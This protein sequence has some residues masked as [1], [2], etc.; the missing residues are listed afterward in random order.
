MRARTANGLL[1]VVAVVATVGV[2]EIA[3]RAL[4]RDLSGQIAA[5][6]ERPIFF[7]QPIVPVGSV[8]FRRPGP[9]AWT[10]N[11]LSTHCQ[12]SKL[13][14]C[15]ADDPYAGGPSITVEYDVQGFRN[16]V[17]MTDWQIAVVGDS[18]TEQG[19]L[20]AEALFTSRLAVDLGIA[21][22]NLGVSFT[23]PLTHQFYLS[24]YARAP[25][26]RDVVL[27]FFEGND[28]EELA[29]ERVERNRFRKTGIRPDR[30][31]VAQTS[32]LRLIW[33]FAQRSP[34]NAGIAPAPRSEGIR[35]RFEDEGR[36]VVVDFLYGVPT[37]AKLRGKREVLE[38]VLAAWQRTAQDLGA[39]SWLLYLPTKLRVL[40]GFL[41]FETDARP[42]QP[43][44]GVESLPQQIERL[45]QRSGMRFIDA[46]PELRRESER[47]RL[48][49]NP[50]FDTHLNRR[51]N[52]IVARVLARALRP[53][54]SGPTQ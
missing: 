12:Q 17:G 25:G 24:H 15:G 39:R 10:G 19:F 36:E 11:V 20:P 52:E 38:E 5:F 41:H 4:G 8:F 3:L 14:L 16:P 46:T 9:D 26:L 34:S 28:L 54:Y 23:G 30:T 29:R 1:A 37:P 47:G 2:A 21:V 44:P 31:L 33:N 27:A 45:A 48:T 53:G 40:D 49:Y 18:F 51:G 6:R 43:A 50:R 42:L 35:G 7:R 13:G 22:R 32:L